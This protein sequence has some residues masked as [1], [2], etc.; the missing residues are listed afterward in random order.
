MDV[1]I[2]GGIVLKVICERSPSNVDEEDKGQRSR[3]GDNHHA[4]KGNEAFNNE[5]IDTKENTHEQEEINILTMVSALK[6]YKFLYEQIP[7]K[8]SNELTGLSVSLLLL[9][10]L[11]ED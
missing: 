9:A 8:L 7:I 1:I 11:P 2:L 4:D 5:T 10:L 3:G 6:F